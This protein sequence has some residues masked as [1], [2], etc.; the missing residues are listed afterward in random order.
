MTVSLCLACKN[1]QGRRFVQSPS[2]CCHPFEGTFY[3]LFTRWIYEI[4]P[5]DDESFHPLA[6]TRQGDVLRLFSQHESK[7]TF[8]TSSSSSSSCV[9]KGSPSFFFSLYCLPHALKR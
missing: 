6:M 7:P 4:K 3:G 2:S 8:S 9:N 1:M 5:K